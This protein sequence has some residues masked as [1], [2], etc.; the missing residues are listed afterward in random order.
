MNFFSSAIDYIIALRL[1]GWGDEGFYREYDF[2]CHEI[3]DFK[4]LEE[5]NVIQA[6]IFLSGEEQ[7]C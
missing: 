6:E 4:T 3:Y 5:S 2:I 1:K 7:Q